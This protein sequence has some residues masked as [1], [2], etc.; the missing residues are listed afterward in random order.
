MY[1]G[2]LCRLS[3]NLTVENICRIL[4]LQTAQWLRILLQGG[5]EEVRLQQ[6]FLRRCHRVQRHFE[7]QQNATFSKCVLFVL[8]TNFF[9]S[10]FSNNNNNNDRSNV[11]MNLNCFFLSFLVRHKMLKLEMPN[12]CSN[13]SSF[14]PPRFTQ[15]EQ[16][17]YNLKFHERQMHWEKTSSKFVTKNR[18]KVRRQRRRRRRNRIKKSS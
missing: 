6:Q 1:V 7:T 9:W 15:R 5:V 11:Y 10:F 16:K 18:E 14:W 3:K 12:I 4:F 13:W 2:N 8:S 17:K